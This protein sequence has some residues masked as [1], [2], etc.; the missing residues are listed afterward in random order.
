MAIIN[1]KS[2]SDFISETNLDGAIDNLGGIT[3]RSFMKFCVAMAATL[4]LPASMG[5]RIAEAATNPQRPPV[6]WLSAQSH[7]YARLTLPWNN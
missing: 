4:G 3:R 2:E 1:Q 5:W 7:Y 6:I